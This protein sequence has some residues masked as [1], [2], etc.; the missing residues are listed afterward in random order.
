MVFW[1]ISL[2][3]PFTVI[4]TRCFPFSK[5][6]NHFVRLLQLFIPQTVHL[7]DMAAVW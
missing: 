7:T 1:I 2:A 6:A 3:L 5:N 4:L